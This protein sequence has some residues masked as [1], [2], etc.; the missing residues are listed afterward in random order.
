[1]PILSSTL[2]T[3]ISS[4]PLFE[5]STAVET[6]ANNLEDYEPTIPIPTNTAQSICLPNGTKVI[7][8][9]TRILPRS[10]QICLSPASTST[11]CYQCFCNGHYQKN[12]SECHCPNCHIIA[13]GHPACN[14]LSI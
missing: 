1:M 10:E 14:C 13:P 11:I 12:C 8:S 4:P 5:T 7:S 2:T 9:P 6:S 3:H